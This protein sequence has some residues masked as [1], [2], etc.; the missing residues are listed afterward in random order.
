MASQ[1]TSFKPH[2]TVSN[3]EQWE[4]DWELWRGIAVS[5]APAPAPMHQWV[6]GNIC[7]QIGNRLENEGCACRVLHETDWRVAEDTVVRPDVAVLCHGLPEKYVDYPPSLIAEVLSPSTQEKD[8]G[9]KKELYQRQAVPYYL[10][11]DTLARDCEVFHLENGVYVELTYAEHFSV[12]LHD[13]CI[14]DIT[15]ASFFE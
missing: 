3:Y 7:R 5:M 12:Q 2:Y 4:G 10:I 1:L 6:A 11:V 15:P 8:R 9:A 14:F 13:D